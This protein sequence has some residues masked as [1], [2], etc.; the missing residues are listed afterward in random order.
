MGDCDSTGGAGPSF[1]SRGK[2]F[3]G[4]LVLRISSGDWGFFRTII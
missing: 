4:D 2:N 1:F 3:G